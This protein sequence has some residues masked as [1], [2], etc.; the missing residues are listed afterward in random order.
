M[1]GQPFHSRT[2]FVEAG[3]AEVVFCTTWQAQAW[4]DAAG[5]LACTLSAA[6]HT[7]S[8]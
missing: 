6:G 3:V 8:G 2:A 1:E 4:I 5:R 7:S